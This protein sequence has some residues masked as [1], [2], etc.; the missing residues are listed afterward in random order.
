MI[1]RHRSR[2]LML[3]VA[4]LLAA[5]LLHAQLVLPLDNSAAV[6]GVKPP[7]FD[8]VSVKEHH[9]DGSS[10]MMRIGSTPSGFLVENFPL[11]TL[12]SQA[13]NIR[14][15]LISG[16]PDWASSMRFDVNAKVAEEDAPM[17]KKLSSSQR[18]AMLIPVLANRFH[19]QVHKEVRTLPTYDLVI[20]K[21]GSKVMVSSVP[22][23][24]PAPASDGAGEKKPMN[25]FEMGPGHFAATN[26]S[27]ELLVSQLAYNTH[28]TVIDKTGLT[29]KYNFEL[30]WTPEQIAAASSDNGLGDQPGSVFTALREQ[31]G[32]KLVPS[33]GPVDTL[34]VDHVEKPSEN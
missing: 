1:L 22:S 7:V 29:G 14:E 11:K 25:R 34:V 5:P 4:F 31:L 10:M 16:L 15:D 17:L 23:S 28:R 8:V 12:I 9:N 32:L 2:S 20:D 24:A 30:K 3:A 6:P 18:S 27:M 13:Y 19:L 26:V 33:K 21:G